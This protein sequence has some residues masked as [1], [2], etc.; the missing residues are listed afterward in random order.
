MVLLVYVFSCLKNPQTRH[1][2]QVQRSSIWFCMS[3]RMLVYIYIF[4][5]IWKMLGIAPYVRSF[6]PPEPKESEP[7]SIIRFVKYMFT[8]RLCSGILMVSKSI[9]LL[10]E[11][12]SN[13]FSVSGYSFM[14]I[15]L[16]RA[17]VYLFLRH[18]PPPSFAQTGYNVSI[19]LGLQI[20]KNVPTIKRPIFHIAGEWM[21][22]YRYS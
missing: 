6:H 15:P 3:A 10:Q 12:H 11:L 20:E 22:F 21:L 9:H 19:A 8:K 7:C 1:T 4:P 16:P 2:Q 13:S 14:P 17:F 5:R 18:P